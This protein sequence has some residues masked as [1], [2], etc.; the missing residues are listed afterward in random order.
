MKRTR[1]KIEA[2]FIAKFLAL[3]F[4]AISRTTKAADCYTSGTALYPLILANNYGTEGVTSNPGGVLNMRSCKTA[5]QTF[6]AVLHNRSGYG[7]NNDNRI[8][9]SFYNLVTGKGQAGLLNTITVGDGSWAESTVPS[10][11]LF[12]RAD[13]LGVTFGF[14]TAADFHFYR[15]DMT[16]KCSSIADTQCNFVLSVLPFHASTLGLSTSK[17]FLTLP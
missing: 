12:F 14:Y 11:A 7:G 1:F 15:Y 4:I 9:L 3:A 13:C 10:T 8:S 5:T 2:S 17:T 16:T 6:M